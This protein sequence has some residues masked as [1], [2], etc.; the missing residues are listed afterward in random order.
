MYDYGA[1]FYDPQ[2]GR[3]TVIDSKAEKFVSYSP[4]VYAIDN[5]IRFLDPD[6]KQIVDA[7]GN[8]IYTQNRGWV[9]NASTD[10]QHIQSAMIKTETGREQWNKM[11]NSPNKINLNINSTGASTTNYG[12]SLPVLGETSVPSA[13]NP[14]TG[15]QEFKSNSIVKVVIYEK[16]IA[17]STVTNGN[18]NTGLTVDQAMAATAGHE[19]VHASDPQNI[20]DNV[21]NRDLPDGSKHDVEV[22]P[23]AVG[24]QIREE[25]RNE[26]KPIE[27][28]QGY[29]SENS[30]KQ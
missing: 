13:R 22:E 6:G 11:V 3:W 28:K 16:A 14:E 1:R 8:V 15:K 29:A 26:L 17:Q 9:K 24:A 27:P 4:Y 19:S 12:N 5:P 2:I 23:K 30:N 21:E 20:H 25:S 18:A 7:K 10:A